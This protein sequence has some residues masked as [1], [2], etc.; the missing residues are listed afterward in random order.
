MAVRRGWRFKGRHARKIDSYSL[1]MQERERS[2]SPSFAE[3]ERVM[4]RI[5]ADESAPLGNLAVVDDDGTNA[6][7]RASADGRGFMYMLTFPDGMRYVG[8]T[9][10]LEKRMVSHRNGNKCPKIGGRWRSVH[11]SLRH[12]RWRWHTRAQSGLGR[13]TS[14][15]SLRWTALSTRQSWARAYHRNLSHCEQH[16]WTYV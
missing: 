9:V 6:H 14:V 5:R 7:K 10:D 12:L 1:R 8:Q 15:A 4:A 2:V 13:H 3:N 11:K 16:R